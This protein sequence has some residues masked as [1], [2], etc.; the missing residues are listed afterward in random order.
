MV[1][2]F[3]VRVGV[4]LAVLV[5]L[6]PEKLRLQAVCH[7]RIRSPGFDVCQKA[8]SLAIRPASGRDAVFVGPRISGLTWAAPRILL[9]MSAIA[10]GSAEHSL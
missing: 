10:R 2:R 5:L 6:L 7:K 8:I 9:A 4:N 3:I 1:V